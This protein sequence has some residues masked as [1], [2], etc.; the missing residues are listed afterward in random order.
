[1]ENLEKVRPFQQ[2]I[3]MISH[4]S[5]CA[6]TRH[7]FSLMWALLACSVYFVVRMNDY[8]CLP[9]LNATAGGLYY[10]T[11]VTIAGFQARV[12]CLFFLVRS[13]DRLAVQTRYNAASRALSSHSHL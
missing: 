7:C 9:I 3:C 11:G 13:Y 10:Q 2:Q 12:G 6:E 8:C 4:F 5:T 1:M